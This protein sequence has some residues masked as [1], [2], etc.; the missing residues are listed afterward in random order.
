MPR[1]LSSHKV[2]RKTDCCPTCKTHFRKHLV[3]VLWRDVVECRYCGHI[4]ILIA[5]ED[6]LKFA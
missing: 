4:W 6:F 2:H 5:L 1:R 3:A